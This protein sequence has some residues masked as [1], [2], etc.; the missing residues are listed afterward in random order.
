MPGFWAYMEIP[1]LDGPIPCCKSILQDVMV[2]FHG[3]FQVSK[4]H[5]IIKGFKVTYLFNL[6]KE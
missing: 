2:I 1:P 3:D 5:V 4:Y 6:Q